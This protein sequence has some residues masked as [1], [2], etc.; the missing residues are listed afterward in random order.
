MFQKIIILTVIALAAFLE[1]AALVNFF[2]ATAVPDILLVIVALWTVRNGFEK[3]WPRAIFAGIFLDLIYFWPVGTNVI[4]LVSVSYLVSFLAK[5]FL[6]SQHAWKFLFLVILTVVS[7]LLFHL[8]YFFISSALAFF[9]RPDLP[10]TQIIF[11]AGIIYKTLA[12]LAILFL[13]YWPVKRIEDFL[14]IYNK[15]VISTKR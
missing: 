11:S 9:G 6:I 15:S 14:S 10:G 1:E 3:T 13:I 5:R 2:P 8:I 7:T 4:A 12:N